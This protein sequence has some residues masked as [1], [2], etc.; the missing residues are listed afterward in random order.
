MFDDEIVKTK[1]KPIK[2]YRFLIYTVLM[3]ITLS[4]LIAFDVKPDKI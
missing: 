2:G 1:G 4:F 3:I